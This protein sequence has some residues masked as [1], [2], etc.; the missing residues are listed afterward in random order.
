MS[1]INDALKRAQQ[2][3][4][5]APPQAPSSANLRPIEPAP[6]VRHSLGLALPVALALVA[7]CVLFFA[8]EFVQKS[9]ANAPAEFVVQAATPARPTVTLEPN[10]SAVS[11]PTPPS[12]TV[13]A[14]PPEKAGIAISPVSESTAPA[15]LDAKETV[16]NSS[17]APEVAP[18]PLKPAPLR[19]QA[20]VWNPARPSALVNGK[21]LFT[22]DKFADMRVLAIT[23][24]SVTLA[25]GGHTNVLTLEQ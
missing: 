5:E 16:Q 10:V 21:T 14:A 13:Q 11:K 20:L 12:P 19:L 25:G 17:A 15:S 9:K 6:R 4:H 24:E 23:Q 8:W 1:L 7:L 22:G 3:Q 2:V 18:A